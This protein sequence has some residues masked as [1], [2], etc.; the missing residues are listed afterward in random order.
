MKKLF[1]ISFIANLLL[2]IVSIMILPE[3]VAIHFGLGGKP[4]SWASSYINA[5]IMGVTHTVIFLIFFFSSDIIHKVPAKYISLP[6]KDYWLNEENI[7]NAAAIFSKEMYLFG[8]ATFVFMF[9]I[10]L[11]TFQA[12]LSTPVVL[13]EDLLL[14]GMGIYLGFTIYW[15]ISLILKFKI[16]KMQ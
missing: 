6:N 14:W 1:V 10:G 4:D 8:V 2:M 5:M 11:L 15:I 13:R 7:S 12:N 9:F 16:P 3:V